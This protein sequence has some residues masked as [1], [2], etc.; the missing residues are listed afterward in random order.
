MAGGYLEVL[1]STGETWDALDQALTSLG[2][3]PVKKDA[4]SRQWLTDWVVW[5]YN[6]RK[7]TGRSKPAFSFGDR[8]LERHQFLMTVKPGSNREHAVIIIVDKKRER[9][10]DLTP[11][12]M[13][14]WLEWKP[15]DL[16]QGAADTFLQRLQLPI[17]SALVTDFVV[18]E[19]ITRTTAGD[20]VVTETTTDTSADVILITIPETGVTSLQPR[21]PEPT[22]AA[23]DKPIREPKPAEARENENRLPVVTVQEPVDTATP[24][25][26][27][28]PEQPTVS[29]LQP[30]E[31]VT[32]Q[33]E[34][35][36]IRIAKS[37]QSAQRA[38]ETVA[39]RPQTMPVEEARPPQPP[40][41]PVASA[42][43]TAAPQT[44]TP[45]HTK[46]EVQ[47]DT[48]VTPAAN[49]LLVSASPAVAWPA[50]LQALHDLDIPVDRKDGQ[51][52]LLTTGWVNADYDKKNHLLVLRSEEGPM[53][54]FNVFGK[55]IERQQFQ[56][57]MVPANQGVRSI[58]YAYNTGY[59]QQIDQTP[60][61]SQTLLVW[62]DQDTSP[63]VALALLRRLR[64][65]I[66]H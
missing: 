48:P 15:R 5:K 65:V 22:P 3:K 27:T 10:E 66:P 14:S 39:T 45:A 46:T 1:S 41:A 23:S 64:I 26:K 13:A 28:M 21:P 2:I 44:A 58:I 6:K 42:V 12:S 43:A 54:A 38:R 34:P 51:Q 33:P 36:A 8:S 4:A 57:V 50:L 20:L 31:Q 56:I 35:A 30:A 62:E 18:A 19:E 59:Q 53:W 55:G 49:G 17:E 25:G 40:A 29:E 61:S 60:D 52:H 9:E 7:G 63:D 24:A 47:P 37:P 32:L 11:D 16:Q